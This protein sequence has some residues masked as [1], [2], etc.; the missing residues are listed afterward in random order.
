[1]AVKSFNNFVN[2][3]VENLFLY[4]ER[5]FYETSLEL[6]C[7]NKNFNIELIENIWQVLDKVFTEKCDFIKF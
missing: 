6:L 3:P 5:I 4:D 7:S 1:M 2:D